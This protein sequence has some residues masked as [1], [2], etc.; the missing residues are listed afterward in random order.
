MTIQPACLAHLLIVD[1]DEGMRETLSDIL[2]GTSYCVE[3][4]SDGEAALERIAT[5]HYD[6]VLMDI[7]MPVLNGVETLERIRALRPCL[8]VILMSGYTEGAMATTIRSQATALVTK[9][10]DLP[11]LMRLIEAMVVKEEG[12]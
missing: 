9:P 6:L 10:L 2:E 12:S 3:Q 1:D 4:A 7:R 8:P 5:Q 11:A